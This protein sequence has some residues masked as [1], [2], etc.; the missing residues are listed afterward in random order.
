MS[1]GRD[2]DKVKGLKPLRPTLVIIG[3]LLISG[4]CS[5]Q[6]QQC[7]SIESPPGTKRFVEVCQSKTTGW[8]CSFCAGNKTYERL[9]EPYPQE[10][11]AE[12]RLIYN[13]ENIVDKAEMDKE[14]NNFADK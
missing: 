13:Q 10:M 11:S 7:I 5:T 4:C 1:E 8:Y 6:C 3:L 2:R 14:F 9:S 12:D